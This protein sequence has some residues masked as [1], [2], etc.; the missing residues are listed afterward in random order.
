VFIV[1]RSGFKLTRGFYI[2]F[3]IFLALTGSF[4]FLLT[5]HVH[6]GPL[7]K[8]KQPSPENNLKSR[9]MS[10]AEIPDCDLP[11]LPNR[12]GPYT[13][14]DH[15]Y[16]SY[17]SGDVDGFTRQGWWRVSFDEFKRHVDRSG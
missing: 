14:K 2:P 10:P 4:G 13:Y 12:E 9:S 6:I 16:Y 7:R 3:I 1:G 5:M 8:L 17:P 11:A 15:P